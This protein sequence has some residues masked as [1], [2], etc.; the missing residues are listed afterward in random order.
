MTSPFEWETVAIPVV[1]GVDLQSPARHVEPRR[2]LGLF[3]ARMVRG[4]GMTR[5][6]GHD[7]SIPQF[8]DLSADRVAPYTPP[9]LPSTGVD[10][11]EPF[12]PNA[13]IPAE[14]LHGYGVFNLTQQDPTG[15]PEYSFSQE[16]RPG[17]LCGAAKRGDEQMIWDGFRFF[18]RTTSTWRP[19]GFYDP[20]MSLGFSYLTGQKAQRRQGDAVMPWARVEKAPGSSLHQ[21]YPDVA[22][23]GVVR[24]YAYSSPKNAALDHSAI[25]S[26]VDSATGVVLQADKEL[27]AVAG[28]QPFVRAIPVGNYV[29]VFVQDFSSA[30][31]TM[32][33][34]GPAVSD[35]LPAW[36]SQSLGVCSNWDV[37]KVSE[38]KFTVLRTNGGNLL[39]AEF[40]AA[41]ATSATNFAAWTSFNRGVGPAASQGAIAIQA[42]TG[43]IC[44][45]WRNGTAL[46]SRIYS[47]N[48]TALVGAASI[49]AG[50]GW[51]PNSHLTVESQYLKTRTA[52]E[53]RPAFRVYWDTTDSA[54]ITVVGTNSI[55][56]NLAGVTVVFAT[57]VI[58]AAPNIT[59][60]ASQAFRVGQRTY[61]W[62]YA[63]EG[64]NLHQY[65][66]YDENL[67][68]CGTVLGGFALDSLGSQL[69]SVNWYDPRPGYPTKDHVVF[70][71]G[72]TYS[73]LGSTEKTE[74]RYVRLDFLPPLRSAQMGEVTYFPGAMSWA[75]DGSV[76]SE[77]TPLSVPHI[78][79]GT[80]SGGGG[81]TAS[82][83]YG[84]RV[85]LG[86][87]N[88][89]GERVV[90]AAATQT[91]TTGIGEGTLTLKLNPCILR[92]TG[93]YYLI[94]RRKATGTTYHLLTSTDPTSSNF[95]PASNSIEA[96]FVDSL[97]DAS[98]GSRE[99]D[100]ANDPTLI[101]SFPAP[102]SEIV[103][104][105]NSRLWLAGG[106]IEMGTVRASKLHAE[107]VGVGFSPALQLAPRRG[108]TP[109]TAIGF[110]GSFGVAFTKDRAYAIEGDGPT[111]NAGGAFWPDPKDLFTDEGALR[112]EG[113]TLL[114]DGLTFVSSS[115][116][117]LI[118]PSGQLQAIG[119]PVDTEVR[120]QRITAVVQTR[121]DIRFYHRGGAV[122][123]D[124]MTGAWGFWTGVGC[125][126]AVEG[127][128]GAVLATQDGY[129]FTEADEVWTDAGSPYTYRVRFA[130]LR[131]GDLGDFQRI[132]RVGALGHYNGNHTLNVNVYMDEN[133]SPTDTWSTAADPLVPW[134]WRR[135]LSRQK[136]SVVSVE[137]SDNGPDDES[138]TLTGLTL[139]LGYKRGLSRIPWKSGQ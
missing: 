52:T 54:G 100:P 25:V 9:T 24:V 36:T 92:R 75:Y 113:V 81:L 31:L 129:V 15:N 48:S 18:S 114:S 80:P 91:F 58:A 95:L 16:T 98:L 20:P 101:P 63:G 12:D 128:D 130:W 62:A 109:I 76:V 40:T 133:S 64:G 116:V 43:E 136:C 28:F 99:G 35:E 3:N 57:T 27:R 104:A 88:S 65:V 107:R 123:M 103:A 122:V 61:V 115:G 94:Y 121:D 90:G 32:Y 14:W 17:I 29:H 10:P 49:A 86:W 34:L 137:I 89:V 22:D 70:H 72:L 19:T 2:L 66:L 68:P 120:E 87:T 7:L 67:L 106:E 112:Q 4:R 138:F 30:D 59:L 110:M 8:R 111:N 73:R 1:A 37:R 5:R 105:G 119:S 124:R 117:R 38:T 93:A 6:R 42:Q 56:A 55:T 23:N 131:R 84:Y 33:T 125:V 45:V 127:D 79:T 60:L 77:A 83:T 69:H 51:S 97:S 118:T 135:R 78:R 46:W 82:S 47:T 132:R 126:G 13:V 134:E 96:T 85:Y 41:G 26:V 44:L 71:M 74:G 11:R 21:F 53:T 139:E 39:V 102:A 108:A 50:G